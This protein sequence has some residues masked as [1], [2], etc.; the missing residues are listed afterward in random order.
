MS[1]WTIATLAEAIR[2]R[3]VSPVEATRTCLERIERLEGRLR[4]FITVDAEGALRAA[5]TLEAEAVAGRVRGLLHGVPMAWKDLCHVRGLPTSC[6]TK[7]AEYFR[8]DHECTAVRRLRRMGAITLGKLN[9]TELA[10]GPFGDNPHH[11]DVQNP[12]RPGH[13]AGGSSSGAGAAV[14]AG[15]AL[16]ALGSDTGGSIRLP[17]A[18][19]GIVGLKPTYGRVSR[20]GVM[21][22][23]WSLD[24]LG[25]MTRTVRDAALLLGAIAGHDPRDATSSRRSVPDYIATL[26]GGVAGLRVGVIE[27]Y[28]FHDLHPEMEA[29][30]R[31]AVE[32]I[33][34]LGARVGE[35]RVP[36]P[37]SMVGVCNIIARAESSTVHARVVRERPHELGPA[38]RARLEVGFHIS[39]HDY[40]Q[41][42]RLRS[43]LTREFIAEVFAEVDAL[44]VP[45]IPEPAPALVDAKAGS[46][47]DVIRRM[48]RF[49]RL[50]RPLNGLGLPA[51]AVPCGF[52]SDGRP[53]AFQIVGRPFD[54]ATVLRL[55]H[56]YEQAAGW[57]RR[58][59]PLD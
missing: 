3:E 59:P 31:A 15:L 34:G 14:A 46:V 17:A 24:H 27:N 40:L 18:C 57:H 49:S 11:G 56:A 39:A 16:G 52:S 9:M 41:A 1:D 21:A 6:G 19:C 43:R 47:D 32:L 5:R 36:D 38:V 26:D 51:L 13:S 10:L 12:W 4:S 23:S 50:T 30:A 54:E 7:T 8:A 44:V 48:G 35:I 20:A 37:E 58:R 45:A 55:G 42:L 53:L 33:A 22:L 25:P 28:Y 2:A 29:G